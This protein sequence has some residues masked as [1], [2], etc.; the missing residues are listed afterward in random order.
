MHSLPALVVLGAS[1]ETRRP[2][3]YKPLLYKPLLFLLL[4]LLPVISR[5]IRCLCPRP[6]RPS[7]SAVIACRKEAPAQSG[8]PLER[9]IAN[10]R[11]GPGR[12]VQPRRLALRRELCGFPQLRRVGS[13]TR[14]PALRIPDWRRRIPHYDRRRLGRRGRLAMRS[15]WFRRRCGNSTPG[16]KRRRGNPDKSLR[17]TTPG[18]LSAHW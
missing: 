4:L 10:P 14:S 15:C 13:T 11:P 8:Q 18:L 16:S 9:G 6:L 7:L 1:H 3:M 2:L 17:P 5:L 12:H